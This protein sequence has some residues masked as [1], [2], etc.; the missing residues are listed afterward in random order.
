MRS[1]HVFLMRT[2]ILFREKRLEIYGYN[3]STGKYTFYIINKNK[4]AEGKDALDEL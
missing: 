4:A 1:F 2:I 3:Y